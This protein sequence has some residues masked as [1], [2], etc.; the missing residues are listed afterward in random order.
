LEIYEENAWIM[1]GYLILLNLK[2]VNRQGGV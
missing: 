1:L 2:C